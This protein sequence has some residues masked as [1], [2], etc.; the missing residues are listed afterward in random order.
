MGGTPKSATFNLCI[1]KA[2]RGWLLM[3]TGD[4]R[5]DVGEYLPSHGEI[6]ENHLATYSLNY[7]DLY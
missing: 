1:R 6:M 3:E 2:A 5:T 4:G 7:S